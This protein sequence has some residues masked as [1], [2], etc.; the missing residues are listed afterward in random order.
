M[1]QWIF[2]SFFPDAPSTTFEKRDRVSYSPQVWVSGKRKT[3]TGK[4]PAIT[5]YLQGR[6]EL[7][8]CEEVPF[9][10]VSYKDGRKGLFTRPSFF[11]MTVCRNLVSSSS[12]Q[13]HF[14]VPSVRRQYP[15]GKDCFWSYPKGK[16]LSTFARTVPPR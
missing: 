11:I 2:I 1:F 13:P 3:G 15:F 8:R 6:G 9:C 4:I 10:P 16:S 12:K 5:N 14:T 7:L